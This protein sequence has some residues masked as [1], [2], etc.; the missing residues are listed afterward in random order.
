MDGEAEVV[1]I[2]TIEKI[3]AF[4][5]DS[6]NELFYL[7][8]VPERD[9]EVESTEY[10]GGEQAGGASGGSPASAQKQKSAAA[11]PKR[12]TGGGAKGKGGKSK[13]KG[14][15]RSK[16]TSASSKAKVRLFQRVFWG[17]YWGVLGVAF[18]RFRS[19][20]CTFAPSRSLCRVRLGRTGLQQQRRRV[21]RMAVTLSEAARPPAPQTELVGASW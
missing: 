11:A 20:S 10:E 18:A 16:S 12:K 19:R 21:Q 4:S 9:P 5:S 6:E 3:G 2:M 7:P 13:G 14:G 15:K 8:T 17:D 1:D